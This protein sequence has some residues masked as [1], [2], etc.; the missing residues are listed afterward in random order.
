M[1]EC[2][3]GLSHLV[4]VL[5][6]LHCTATAF[7]SVHEFTGQAQIHRLLATLLGG[8]T[9]PAHGKG[10]AAH[11]AHFNRHLIVRATYTAALDFDD[12]LDVVDRSVEH[13]DRLFAS[14][15]LN[16]VKGTV[17]DALCNGLLARQHDNVHEFGELYA[18]KLGIGEDFTLRNFATT[19]HFLLPCDSSVEP[20]SRPRHLM[21][22]VCHLHARAIALRCTESAL[23]AGYWDSLWEPWDL[24]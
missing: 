21:K 8:F 18:A 24:G 13:L 10:Q 11:R 1:A 23:M 19:R 6:L 14:F 4:R 5:T 12:G 2:L 15:S 9:Q 16:L 22:G 3:V 20:L 7:G 17:H